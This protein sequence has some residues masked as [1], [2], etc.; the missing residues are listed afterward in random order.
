M[1]YLI[2]WVS[3]KELLQLKKAFM[4]IDRDH[5]GIIKVNELEKAFQMLNIEIS[6]GDIKKIYEAASEQ[7]EGIDYIDF[8]VA[9]M[10]QKLYLKKE[11]LIQAFKYFD[12]DDSGYIDKSDIKNALLRSGKKIVN[13]NDIDQMMKEIK[14]NNQGKISMGDFLKLFDISE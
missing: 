14:I 4:A 2:N 9:S 6:D 12:V 3:E 8:I 13:E 1:R 5:T 11:K 10:D 7:K